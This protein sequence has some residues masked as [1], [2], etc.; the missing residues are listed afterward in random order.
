MLTN[1]AQIVGHTV[2]YAG[3]GG[4]GAGT[5]RSAQVDDGRLQLNIDGSLVPIDEVLGVGESVAPAN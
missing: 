4:S 5:V 1:G 3:D 2:E